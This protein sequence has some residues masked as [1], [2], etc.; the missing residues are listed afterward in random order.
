[1]KWAKPRTLAQRRGD[2]A[3]QAA[4]N[5]LRK[6]KLKIVDTNVSCRYGEIDI[7]AKDNQTLVF[8][9]VRYR[10]QSRYGSGAESVSS[11]KQKKIIHSAMHYLQKKQLLNTVSC[12]FD[13]ISVTL[14]PGD[15]VPAYDIHWIPDA[16]C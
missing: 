5:Y 4:V 12:R 16:F 13:V 2:A 6:E 9:E 3:E 11:Q 8:V 10:T 14:T 1:M 7:I 15:K